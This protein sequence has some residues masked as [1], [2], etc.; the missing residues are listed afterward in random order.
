MNA[1]PSDRDLLRFISAFTRVA[2][3][4]AIAIVDSLDG[5][6]RAIADLRER[7]NSIAFTVVENAGTDETYDDG[8]QVWS[9]IEDAGWWMVW[10]P[11]PE[12]QWNKPAELGE[13]ITHD[14]QRRL[15]TILGGGVVTSIDLDFD[16]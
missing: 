1:K 2:L 6:E 10:H 7:L 13:F 11:D 9:Y 15:A 16:L 14:G 8:R 5:D 3:G 12:N 4:N